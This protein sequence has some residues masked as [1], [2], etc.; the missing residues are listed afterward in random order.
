LRKTS[1]S[2][3]AKSFWLGELENVSLGHGVS[4]LQWSG[5][6]VEYLHDTP[7]YSFMPSPTFAHNPEGT[8]KQQARAFLHWRKQMKRRDG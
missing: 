6:G 8:I 1:V 7:A 4:L 2:G 3:S 5:G